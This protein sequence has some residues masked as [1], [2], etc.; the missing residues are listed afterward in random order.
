MKNVY[1]TTLAAARSLDPESFDNNIKECLQ[2]AVEQVGLD[3]AIQALCGNEAVVL[4]QM[5][6]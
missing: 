4:E 3:V 2:S 6:A 5:A 1:F